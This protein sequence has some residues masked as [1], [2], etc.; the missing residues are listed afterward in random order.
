MTHPTFDE[1]DAEIRAARLAALNRHDGPRCGDYVEFADGVTRRIS[2]VWPDGVQTSH[3]GSW[4]LGAE[5]CSF[6]GALYVSVPM[7]TLTRTAETRPGRVW[8]FH[9]GF[10]QAHN[11]VETDVPFRVYRCSVDA[12]TY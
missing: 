9:H 6:S 12:P 4:H 7:T 5:G 1:R 3:S 10:M 11:G 2:H 8:F